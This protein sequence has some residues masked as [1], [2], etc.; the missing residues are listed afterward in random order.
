MV[1]HA[2]GPVDVEGFIDEEK[3][4]AVLFANL[5]GEESGNALVD[6]LI[7]KRS[8]SGKLPFT[9]GKS[10][11]D[12]GPAATILRKVDKQYPLPQVSFSEGLMIDYRHFDKHDIMPR[13]EFGYGLSYTT[14]DIVD[15][16]IEIVG[17][18]KS[19]EPPPRPDLPIAP[20][21]YNSTLPPPSDALFPANFRRLHN[22]QYPYIDSADS[23]HYQPQ[24][25][26]PSDP[27][28]LPSPAGGGQGGNPALFD[29][30]ISLNVTVKNTGS[31]HA[32]SAVVQ[33][34]VSLPPVF[35][36]PDSYELVEFPVRVLRDFEK[37]PLRPGAVDTVSLRLTRRDLSYWSATRQNWLMPCALGAAA[38]VNVSVGF[39][40]RDLRWAR[41]IGA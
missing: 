29:T 27:H 25:P 18:L 23:I 20:P 36:D 2:T 34:Y 28:A 41:L 22:Y 6:I 37:V 15:V 12:Y 11:A 14:F 38:G 33:T 17:D 39:S 19:L 7:G 30:L 32:A 21:T 24:L 10:L 3:V 9:M 35:R 16:K 13:F 8:P 5:P 31:H 1:I 40:S 4:K 26:P